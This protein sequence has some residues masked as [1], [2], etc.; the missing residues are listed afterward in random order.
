MGKIQI[1]SANDSGKKIQYFSFGSGEKS[2][3][4]IPG[5]SVVSVMKSADAIARAYGCF[6]EDYKVFVFDRPMDIS[7][8]YSVDKMAEVIASAMENLGIFDAFVFGASQGGMIAQVIAESYPKLVKKLVLGSTAREI[9]EN[10]KK[11]VLRWKSLAEKG[12]PDKLNA[13]FFETVFSEE[14]VKKYSA[15][16]PL[17]M[18]KGTEKD[19][20]RFIAQCDA[21]ETFDGEKGLKSIKCETLVIGGKEDK[22]FYE[23]EQ[24]RLAENIGCEIKLYEGFGHAVY[25]EAKDY[26]KVLKEFFEK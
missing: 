16:L 1:F 8:L 5:I 21:C 13:D 14:T 20:K 24:I 10:A 25:D 6:S 23:S 18:K 3:V 15:M 19:L 22:I 9:T 2:L 26:K 17:L 12:E 4:I 7:Y 11:V